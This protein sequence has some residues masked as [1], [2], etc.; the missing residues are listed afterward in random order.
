MP[1]C[2]ALHTKLWQKA[3]QKRLPRYQCE[4]LSNLHPL[5]HHCF[6]FPDDTHLGRF[7][8]QQQHCDLLDQWFFSCKQNFH[9]FV[10][11]AS[12]LEEGIV[13][14]VILLSERLK[15]CFAGLN[16][17]PSF[18]P[19][20]GL[21]D[22]EAL[23]H[24]IEMITAGPE[25]ENAI[26]LNLF[27]RTVQEPLSHT[28]FALIQQEFGRTSIQPSE[29]YDES[30]TSWASF[31]AVECPLWGTW[32]CWDVANHSFLLCLKV[33][34]LFFACWHVV[35]GRTFAQEGLAWKGR[36]PIFTEKEFDAVV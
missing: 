33:E 21:E 9:L 29:C 16:D 27:G 25:T 24:G 6:Q 32:S 23:G 17:C 3:I 13:V 28:V 26:D 22:A 34:W 19:E 14:V 36:Q 30:I 5:A 7:F 20:V 15:N 35:V 4:L 18:R 10:A 11:L 12:C 2:N 31:D 1:H 8:L